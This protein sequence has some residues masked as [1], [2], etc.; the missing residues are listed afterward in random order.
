MRKYFSFNKIDVHY[1][2]CIRGPSA[3]EKQENRKDGEKRVAGWLSDVVVMVRDRKKKKRSIIKLSLLPWE[4]YRGPGKAMRS[5]YPCQLTVSEKAF[6]QTAN[7]CII[8][9]RLSVDYQLACK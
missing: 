2:T 6:L 7:E 1:K 4:G 5:A 8:R 9:Y 3:R